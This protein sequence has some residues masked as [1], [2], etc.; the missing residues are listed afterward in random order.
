MQVKQTPKWACDIDSLR[1]FGIS[2]RRWQVVTRRILAVRVDGWVQLGTD[3]LGGYSDSLP[4]IC[5]LSAHS[6]R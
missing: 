6:T 3:G 4:W 2:M 1:L 5:A